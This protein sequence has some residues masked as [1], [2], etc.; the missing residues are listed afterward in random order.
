MGCRGPR[1]RCLRTGLDSDVADKAEF[2]LR[3][4]TAGGIFA[5]HFDPDFSQVARCFAVF[6]GMILDTVGSNIMS[7]SSAHIEHIISSG[8]DRYFET[9]QIFARA[10]LR[11]DEGKTCSPLS[12]H[13][14]HPLG[15]VPLDSIPM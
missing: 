13:P 4:K 11:S 3:A 15:E 1:H 12:G 7:L 6:N 9:W 10:F 8:M 14:L 5:P 2:A